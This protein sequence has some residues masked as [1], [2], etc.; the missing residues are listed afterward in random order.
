M[1]SLCLLGLA[2]LFAGP[3]SAQTEAVRAES[4]IEEYLAAREQLRVGVLSGERGLTEI[5]SDLR[6]L[7]AGVVRGA[8]KR[9]YQVA[10]GRRSMFLA[11]RIFALA[12]LLFVGDEAQKRTKN[13]GVRLEE[14]DG[15]VLAVE[16][17]ARIMAVPPARSSR[18]RAMHLAW[19]RWSPTAST[20]STTSRSGDR[21]EATANPSRICIPDE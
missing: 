18:I 6:G 9:A 4:L 14:L 15:F 10:E 13:A 1:S 11:L 7:P 20:S 2:T 12:E 16:W 21:L 19:N 8:A 3:V 17:E 5:A